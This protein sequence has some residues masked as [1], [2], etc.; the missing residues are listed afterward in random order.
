MA[1][2]EDIPLAVIAIENKV[3]TVVINLTVGIALG[4]QPID[5]L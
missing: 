4:C 1:Y 3:F 2:G 5:K